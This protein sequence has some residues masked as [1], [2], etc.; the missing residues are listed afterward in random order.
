[1]REG[2]P[3]PRSQ[4]LSPPDKVSEDQRQPTWAAEC[5]AG[6]EAVFKAGRA[7]GLAFPPRSSAAVVLIDRLQLF[8]RA[9]E[10]H[11]VG[12]S[13]P[14]TRLMSRFWR[15]EVQGQ[16]WALHPSEGA[17]R[18]LSQALSWLLVA[19]AA[20]QLTDGCLLPLPL[21]T[22]FP[23]CTSVSMSTFLPFGTQSYWIGAHS[24]DLILT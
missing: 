9:A 17:G 19:S 12:S 14:Q 1:M 24:H 7:P 13:E 4:L 10:G 11:T 5:R 6:A 8:A 20:P 23:L 2:A 16:V 22:V 21:H 15:P 18:C 3:P